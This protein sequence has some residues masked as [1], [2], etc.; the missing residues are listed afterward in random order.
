MRPNLQT[1]RMDHGR[2]HTS[3]TRRRDPTSLRLSM[4]I[5]SRH[6]SLN[7]TNKYPSIR[8]GTTNGNE[9]HRHGTRLRRDIVHRELQRKGRLFTRA[10]VGTRRR[11]EMRH[12]SRNL[13][14][15]GSTTR[16]VRRHVNSPRGNT[17]TRDQGTNNRGSKGANNTTGCGII[18]HAMGI[19]YC[20]VSSGSRVRRRGGTYTTPRLY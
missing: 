6:R 1:M 15:R 13:C 7:T 18:K 9:R 2:R 11:K 14:T 20:Y 4:L 16:R 8:R 3:V 12:P 17:S 19:R 10:K 5:R